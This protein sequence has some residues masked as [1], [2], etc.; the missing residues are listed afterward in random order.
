VEY[1][2]S[3]MD[4]F[5]GGVLT[6]GLTWFWLN[7]K[8]YFPYQVISFFNIPIF[9]LFSSIASHFICRKAKSDYIRIGLRT[10]VSAWL[11]SLLFLLSFSF[12]FDLELLLILLFCYFVGGLTGT[13]I[14]QR[15]IE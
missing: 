4:Y 10:T 9:I 7:L 6:S 3:L 8:Y 2:P 15:K 1:K 12:N 11:I 14:T 5:A 13:F